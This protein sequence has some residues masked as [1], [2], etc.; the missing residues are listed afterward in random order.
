[1]N[2]YKSDL[3]LK[4][5]DHYIE[6]NFF[7]H[8]SDGIG[9][10]IDFVIDSWFYNEERE[11]V[12]VESFRYTTKEFVTVDSDEPVAE[13]KL[14]EEEHK[15]IENRITDLDFKSDYMEFS[16][17]WQLENAGKIEAADLL[18][19]FQKFAGE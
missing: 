11:D 2:C 13:R 12:E 7:F 16:N 15:E 10:W 19:G 17:L 5:S 6:G 1:M 14:T 8:L 4:G 3:V 9:C 18:R